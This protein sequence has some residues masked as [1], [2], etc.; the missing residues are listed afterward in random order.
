MKKILLTLAAAFLLLPAGAGKLIAK[1][2]DF[3]FSSETQKGVVV[4]Q[5]FYVF[6]PAK[7]Y[8]GKKV[9]FRAD[10]KRLTGNAPM[11]ITFRCSTAPNEL[12]VWKK[13]TVDYK[14]NGET[15]PVE[16]VLDIP[17]LDNIVHFNMHAGFRRMGTEKC[18][19]EM[20]NIR[21]EEFEEGK[22]AAKAPALPEGFSAGVA[23]AMVTRPLELVKNGKVNFVIVTADKPDLIASHAAR[24]LQEHFKLACGTAPALIKESGYKSGPAI[25]VGESSVARKYGLSPSM[26]APENLVVARPSRAV[27]TN[28]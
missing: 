9:V 15:V 26:L 8:R 21:F 4:H 22:A 13:F 12:R 10:A 23:A 2:K 19:W 28:I 6:K 3:V 11:G 20:K 18:V 1:H 25:M 5:A 27:G 16:I 24:E 17:D 14:K 7:N